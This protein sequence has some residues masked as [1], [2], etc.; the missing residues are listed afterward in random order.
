[1]NTSVSGSFL[2]QKKVRMLA[3]CDTPVAQPG[4]AIS[5]FGRVALNIFTAWEKIW[6][7]AEGGD[8]KAEGFD[9]DIWAIGF[10]GWGYKALLE[11]HP[12]WNLI[13]AGAEWQSTEMLGCFLKLLATG[14]YTHVWFLLNADMLAHAEFPERLKQVCREKNIHSTLYYPVDAPIPAYAPDSNMIRTVDC[15]VTFTEYGRLETQKYAGENP[16]QYFA[17]GK[18]IHVLPH[19]LDEHFTPLPLAERLKYRSQFQTSMLAKNRAFANENDFLLLNVN[20]NEHRKDLLRSLE[21]LKGLRDWRVPAKLV[22]RSSRQSHFGGCDLERAAVQLGLTQDKDWAHIG[23]VPEAHM[24]GL[25]AAADLFLTTTLGEG[26]GLGITE[27]LACGTPVALP[28]NTSCQEIAARIAEFQQPPDAREWPL[29]PQTV[30]MRVAND[31]VCGP[32]SRL[33]RRVDLT[34]A[35]T[36]IEAYYQRHIR[37]VPFGERPRVEL[38]DRARRW[39]SWE[40]VAYEFLRFMKIL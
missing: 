19:G 4:Q 13:P 22:I 11:K 26:W 3:M 2:P 35:I 10:G 23:P 25:Y 5:G 17:F 30:L 14:N 1:M 38:S 28:G 36:A 32:D 33:R 27:A 7:R 6:P 24:R 21:I 9:L 37:A 31:Y 34:P 39:L 18:P 29:L 40:V 20:K 16:S 8:Q 12:R 15:A